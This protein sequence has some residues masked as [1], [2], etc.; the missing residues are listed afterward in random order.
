M[1]HFHVASVMLALSLTSTMSLAQSTT[2]YQDQAKLHDIAKA[3]SPER[4]EA[5]IRTL[6]G[7]GTRHTLSETES[8]TQGIGAARRWI[9]NEFEQISQACG[10]CLEVYFQAKTISGETRIPDAT[11]VVS[12]IAVQRG[13]HDPNRYVLMSGDI[14]SRISDVMNS[15]S[16]SPGANDNAS[17]VAGTL[18]AARVLSKYKFNG[19]IVYAALAGEEQGLFGGKILA[20]Q[21]QKDG[22]RIKAVLN[23][24]MIGN[25]EG[26]NGVINN[27][28]ARI[29]AEGT[30]QTETPEE[31]RVRRFTGGEV[32]SPSRNLARYIDLMADR[33]IPN[34]DTMVIYRLDRFGRG[35][36]HRPFN[37][38][39]YP[40]VRIMETNE[41]YN[42][43]HQDI[44]S[45]NGIDY[46]DT[47]EGVNFEYAAKLTALNAV[48]LAGMAW[49]PAPPAKVEINGAVKPS[50]TLNWQALDPK[51][52][53]Q[54][55]GYKIYWRYTDAPQWQFSRFV[56][57]VNSYTL[58]NIVIDNY[59]FGVASV[60]QDGAESPV[61]FP[62]AAGA[63]GE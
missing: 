54:L 32:D 52:N 21:A 61:V 57:N 30:R 60:S 6:V 18:E 8:D 1:K 31:A 50:T 19:S 17:G 44:R 3:V 42:R 63:F 53:P 4:I 7:F 46:G 55:K 36:H 35:G 39:G 13:S 22:W 58:D 29:F 9:K 56:G 14:D 48:S 27:T 62:G 45:E 34:L 59:F 51:Q 40:G 25:I 28:T 2:D 16:I 15:T 41:N 12:V 10:G 43:Q 24:D 11:E 23:N 20:E 37:D 47:I 33:Y 38:L 49:A 26:I 5:D